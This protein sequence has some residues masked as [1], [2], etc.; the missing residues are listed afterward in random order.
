[1]Q[2]T[3]GLD[4]SMPKPLARQV[5]SAVLWRSGSQL[6]AQLVMWSATFLVIRRLDPSDYGLFAMTQIVLALMGLMNG[7]S[8]TGALVQSETIDR[9]HVAQ[10]FGALI[11]MNFGL[12]AAQVLLAPAAA[13]YFRQPIV[14]D[15]LRVQAVLHLFTPFI[16]MPQALL[17][18]DIDFRTQARVNFAAAGL[19]AIAGPACAYAGLGVWTLVIA[20]ITLFGARAVGL[21]LLGRWLIRPSFRFTGA[22]AVFGFG[23]A[24]LVSELLWFVQTQADVFIAGRR[25]D[26]HRLGIYTTA[27]FLSQILVNKFVPAL[28]EVAFPTYA[29]MQSD[30][31]AVARA[32]AKATCLILIAAMP[33][34]LG[35]SVAADPLVR[36]V[37]GDKW[38]Q[39]IPVVRILGLAMPFVTLQILFH[40][41]TNALGRPGIGAWVSAAGAVIM[42][43]AFLIGVNHGATG[44]AWA[45]LIA[46]PLLTFAAAWLSLPVIGLGWSDLLNAIR[47]AVVAG[48][49]M[50]AAVTGLDRLLPPLAPLPRLLLL[51]SSGATIYAAALA[52]FAPRVLREFANMVR[53]RTASA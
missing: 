35:M 22:G 25:L 12:A 13:A 42:P 32:F 9:R 51:G 3:P 36:T 14:A 24:I 26:A 19:A 20:P 17:S 15:M 16:M 10:V 7:Y 33:F 23:S 21:A 28:N 1:M 34:C 41:A 11:L 29:R 43:A 8:F 52:A 37:L 27:L 38:A 18:R 39:A 45:W 5:R 40:P 31:A 30:P 53:A 6:A 47:P 4:E 46:F 48:T 44:M 50:A 49:L 2:S